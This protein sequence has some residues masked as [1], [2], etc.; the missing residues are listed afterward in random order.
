[1]EDLGEIPRI[2][3]KFTKSKAK[4][5]H[6]RFVHVS[7]QTIKQLRGEM[8]LSLRIPQKGALEKLFKKTSQDH[9]CLAFFICLPTG[10]GKTLVM[11]LAP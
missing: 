11:A 10:C 1:M 7:R 2:T 3:V 9:N 4:F 6:A 5:Y 8:K